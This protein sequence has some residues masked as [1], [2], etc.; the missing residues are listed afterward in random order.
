[1]YLFI[2]LS[3]ITL[4]VMIVFSRT[5]LLER[6]RGVNALRGNI[7]LCTVL[8]I[9]GFV[10]T[11]IGGLALRWVAGTSADTL[12]V[13]LGGLAMAVGVGACFACLITLHGAGAGDKDDAGM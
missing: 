2:I 12:A 7:V 4:V 1:M 9:G 10:V 8:V 13:G 5:I 11:Q 3:L 6:R